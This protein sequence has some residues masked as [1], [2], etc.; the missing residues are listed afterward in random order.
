MKGLRMLGVLDASQKLWA[1][2]IVGSRESQGEGQS[3]SVD[4]ITC[5]SAFPTLD[6]ACCRGDFKEVKGMP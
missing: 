3:V 4:R 6:M 2:E 5:G 1:R